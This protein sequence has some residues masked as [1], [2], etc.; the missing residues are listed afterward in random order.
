MAMPHRTVTGLTDSA[1]L[2]IMILAPLTFRTDR[3]ALT[4]LRIRT[5]V[6]QKKCVNIT[7]TIVVSPWF[8]LSVHEKGMA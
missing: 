8:G 3:R 4:K 1:G 7:S 6:D 2:I 5:N